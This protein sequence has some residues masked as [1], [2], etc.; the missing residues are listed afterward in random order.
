[1]KNP[2]SLL[3]KTPFAYPIDDPNSYMRVG[4]KY[5]KL[6]QLLDNAGIVREVRTLWNRETC[7][8]DL[9]K[10][11]FAKIKKY[12]GP[13]CKPDHLNYSRIVDNYV[14]EYH[15]LPWNPE[16][17]NYN[18]ILNFICHIFRE[19]LNLGLDYL[20]LLYRNPSQPLP[21]LCLVSNERGTGKST[22]GDLLQLIFQDNLAFAKIEDLTSRFNSDWVTKLLIIFN[23]A[24]VTT[25]HQKERLK[26]LST[27]RHTSMEGKY[28]KKTQAVFFGKFMLFSNNEEDMINLDESEDR[29]W[30]RKIVKFEC[31]D[32]HLLEKMKVQIPHFLAF[33][34]ARE[35]SVPLPLSRMWFSK[36]QI[37][38]E[39]LEKLKKKRVGI[40][41]LEWQILQLIKD[42][43]QLAQQE[44]GSF[45]MQEILS[46][47]TEKMLPVTQVVCLRLFRD[48]KLPQAGNTNSYRPFLGYSAGEP[49]ISKKGRHY[50]ITAD[51]I[52]KSL[53]NMMKP[54][55]KQQL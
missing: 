47:G 53:M 11:K 17:G 34:K 50:T 43:L 32:P 20:T 31:E 16:V 14:N 30:I 46:R 26:D 5:Y 13:T 19:H 33:L 3:A 1:M 36:E 9:G 2:E 41:S 21:I 24:L 25:R 48:W 18:L 37:H 22:F 8:E 7:R 10:S 38:T 54:S 40:K 29:Y 49:R 51:F 28:E 52:Q 6:Q 55:E 12:E 42:D 44:T 45:T 39:A 15:P 27:A 35:L 4:T 23:E